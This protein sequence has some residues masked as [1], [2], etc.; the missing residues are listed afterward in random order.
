MMYLVALP[1][2]KIAILLT[3][4]RIFQQKNFRMLVYGA[5]GLNAAYAI[6]FVLVTAFQCTPIN[7]AWH[8]WDNAHPGRCNNV[9]AQSWSSAAINIVLDII[10]VALPMPM[11]WRMELNK[12]KKALVMLMFGVGI[13]VT[14]VSILRLQVLVK[15]GDSKN[16]TYD[17][18]S[19][20]YWSIVELHTAVVCACMP[21][22]RNLIRRAFPKLMGQSTAGSSKPSSN[23]SG[24]T[25]VASGV[26]K[27]GNEIFV[28]PRHSDD[29]AFIPLE[30]VSTHK[31]V[32]ARTQPVTPPESI[33][34]S[35]WGSQ[36]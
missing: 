14:I 7:L 9:N 33:H 28:R 17:Y 5:L 10:V 8:H 11:L 26:Y 35:C 21:G 13:F 6:I 19:A 31:L 12:R 34:A 24:R 25:A 18:K 30:N 29:E 32:E 27:S 15:F 3:Y 23:L 16:I 22:I 20:G 36:R 1:A 4:L 2:V